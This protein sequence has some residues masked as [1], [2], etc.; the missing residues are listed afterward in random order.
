LA[1]LPFSHSVV[2]F[3]PF[4]FLRILADFRV[5]LLISCAITAPETSH[6]ATGRASIATITRRV[7]KNGT[8]AFKAEVRVQR[9]GKVYQKTRTFDRQAV[10]RSWAASMESKAKEPGALDILAHTGVTVGELVN[11]YVEEYDS[12]FGRTKKAD[13]SALA[14]SSLAALNA[15]TL[16]SGQIIDHVRLRRQTVAPSTAINDLVWLRTVFRFAR[17]AKG[18]LLNMEVI[19]DAVAFCR[20]EK[21]I[22]KSR[23]RDRRPTADELKRLTDH[24]NRKRGNYPMAD[25]MWFAVHSARREAE[26]CRLLWSDNLDAEMTGLVRD[27]KHPTAKIGNHRR[28]KYTAEGWEIVQ[29]QPKTD[30]RIFPYNAKTLSTFFARACSILEIKDLRWHDLR[31]EATSRL[32]EA[33]YAIV[34]VQ[35][36]TLHE[37]WNT[38]KRYTHLRPGDVKHR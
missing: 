6:G 19:E 13:L 31:H 10:A 12:G 38:L 17:S 21:L 3:P 7:R 33:G 22:A 30:D 25:L 11:W 9:D 1:C 24:F 36:F 27:A 8:V 34:E 18:L 20:A 15:L 35:Q 28:F 2:H 23:R 16:T 29:R 37:D 5:L 26:I 4:G 14:K 32:F